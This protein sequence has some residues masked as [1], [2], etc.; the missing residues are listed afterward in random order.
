[1]GG[2]T[3]SIYCAP[4]GGL[5]VV[6]R[7][8]P[9]WARVFLFYEKCVIKLI[10][11]FAWLSFFFLFFLSPDDFS[12]PWNRVNLMVLPLPRP[13]TP[14]DYAVAL[15]SRRPDVL[16]S[17]RHRRHRRPPTTEDTQIVSPDGFD[18][19][20][21]KRSKL[22]RKPDNMHF[23]QRLPSRFRIQWDGATR[24]G[25]WVFQRIQYIDIVFEQ[26]NLNV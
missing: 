17:R 25:G 24:M 6:K 9:L 19:S 8:T 20:S 11:N 10:L 12:S 21:S 23:P 4:E 7:G 13:Q 3:T 14:R 26:L 2:W 5:S 16:T 1:M 22:N 15:T 18:I